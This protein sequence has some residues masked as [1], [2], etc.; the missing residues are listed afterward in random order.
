[1]K[2]IVHGHGG[3]VWVKSDFGQGATFFFTLSESGSEIS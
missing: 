3:K 2:H 1:V